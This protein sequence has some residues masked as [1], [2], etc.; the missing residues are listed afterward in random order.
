MDNE[1][2]RLLKLDSI[3][4]FRLLESEKQRL[5]EWKKAQK[6]IKPTKKVE[7][8]TTENKTSANEVKLTK[9]VV[10]TEDK[11]NGKLGE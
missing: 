3:K 8:G 6:R 10:A 9:N 7:T 11:E 2:K 5:A 4:G 1:I